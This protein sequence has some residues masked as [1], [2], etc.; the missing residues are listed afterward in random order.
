MQF[1]LSR[2]FEKDIAKLTKGTKQ[3]VVSALQKFVHNPEESSLNN[4]RLSGKWRNYY[5][6]NITGDMRAIYTYADDEIVRFVAMGTHS[7]LYG[8]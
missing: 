4:H 1:I 2:Q 5:S 6:I 3:K 7:A 8:K